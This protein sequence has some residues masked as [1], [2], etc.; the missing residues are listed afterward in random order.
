MVVDCICSIREHTKSLTYEILVVDNAS[1][2]GSLDVLG[3]AFGDE[4]TLIASPENLGFGRA[5]NLGAARARGKYLFLLNPDTILVNDAVNILF[6]YL[7]SNPSVGV[8]GGNLYTP[9]MGPAPSFCRSFD[10]LESE[11][12]KASWRYLIGD[13][14]RT[15]LSARRGRAQPISEFNHTDSPE[16]VAYIFGA[17]MMLPKA[18]FDRAGGFDPDF[19]MYGEEEELTWRITQLGLAVVCVPQ[20]R[21]IHLE[22]ATVK[23]QDEF[24]SRQF[25]MRMNG[26]LTYY[27]KRFGD[28]GAAEFYRLRSL[29]YE[30]LM[31]L[32]RVQRKL[33]PEFTPAVQRKYLGEVYETFRKD[34][35][36]RGD[37]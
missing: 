32:A 15:K 1:G 21:I 9:E 2:D 34:A 4:I 29:R 24:S 35:F 19:F 12:S 13:K 23:K 28:T 17:D 31:T 36:T 27:K 16:N 6:D 3:N 11:R 18:V 5:N 25:K 7:E 26:T 30:R 33:T 10:D 14:I 22:G 20:A 37:S 8:A